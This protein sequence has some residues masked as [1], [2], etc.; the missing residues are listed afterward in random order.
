[1]T[2]TG[3]ILNA[4]R[5]SLNMRFD[6][7]PGNNSACQSGP[8][9]PSSNVT[10]DV[11]MSNTGSNCTWQE[12]TAT[13]AAMLTTTP[14]KYFPD[15][16]NVASTKTPQI[17]GYPVIAA[18]TSCGRQVI[19]LPIRSALM[20]VSATANGT[21]MPISEVITPESPGQQNPVSTP[22]AMVS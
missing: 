18:I 20:A 14:P 12:N 16:P 10:K 17:M 21:S 3:N 2:E 9:S 5:D 22:T 15:A 8:C 4:V 13:A 7:K 11:V 19:T 1:M 6:F